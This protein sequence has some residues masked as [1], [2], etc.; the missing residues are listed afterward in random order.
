MLWG[1][2][3]VRGFTRHAF[4]FLSSNYMGWSQ[5]D[6][7]PARHTPMWCLGW[8]LLKSW[9]LVRFCRNCR[10]LVLLRYGICGLCIPDNPQSR[11]LSNRCNV[12]IRFR[13]QTGL[14]DV[15]EEE[16]SPIRGDPRV[17]TC[18]TM[19]QLLSSLR[20]SV[21]GVSR[22]SHS[23]QGWAPWNSAMKMKLLCSLSYKKKGNQRYYL[24]AFEEFVRKLRSSEFFFVKGCCETTSVLFGMVVVIITTGI[25]CSQ[26]NSQ[27]RCDT[28]L[29]EAKL[30]IWMHVTMLLVNLPI[31]FI[32]FFPSN[33]GNVF[34]VCAWHIAFVHLGFIVSSFKPWECFVL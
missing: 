5:W 10:R 12:F 30:H 13:A 1:W 14:K 9:S 8:V 17:I 33:S 7:G 11:S 29:P 22:K 19:N 6:I 16:E 15:P 21:S 25:L 26:T 31:N 4:F 18:P 32:N 34:I 27:A 20:T 28:R 24:C 23:D 2:G 3:R